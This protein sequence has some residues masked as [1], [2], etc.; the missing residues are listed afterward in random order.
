MLSS[1]PLDYWLL[2]L[3]A[4]VS[5][6]FNLAFVIILFSVRRQV[7]AGA[8]QAAAAIG[9]LRQATITY[10]V[11]I[12]QEMPIA[13]S[14]PINTTVNAPLDL[15]VPI[16]TEATV[17]LNTPFG[18]FPVTFPV[19]VTV[20]VHFTPTIP[21][22]LNVPISTKIPVNLE[23]PIQIPLSETVLSTALEPVQKY[24]DQL[25]ASLGAP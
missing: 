10:T 5:L 23:V 24:L 17:P 11:H 19:E 20:P 1:R 12:D 25:A 14:V 16:K 6:L 13:I 3:V 15:N 8:Q 22:N 9:D 18:S 4:L 7:G 2:W 21:I